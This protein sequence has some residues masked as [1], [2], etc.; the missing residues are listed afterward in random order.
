MKEVFYLMEHSINDG[1]SVV[2]ISTEEDKVVDYARDYLEG[3]G[4]YDEYEVDRLVEELNRLGL[5]TI[6][7]ELQLEIQNKV[8]I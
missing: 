4:F 3:F 1:D 8:L 6:D 7:E 2:V 5:V